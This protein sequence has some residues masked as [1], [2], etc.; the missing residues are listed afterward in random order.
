MRIDSG[1]LYGI[2]YL[3]CCRHPSPP[4]GFAS[5][6]VCQ[7]LRKKSSGSYFGAVCFSK[8]EVACHALIDV[9]GGPLGT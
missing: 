5:S 6:A 3:S 4:G 1:E 7:S 2:E 8:L 9:A